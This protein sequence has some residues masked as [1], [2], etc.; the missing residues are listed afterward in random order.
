MTTA[1]PPEAPEDLYTCYLR[2]MED[3]GKSIEELLTDEKSRN[4]HRRTHKPMPRKEFERVV[5]KMELERRAEFE[6]MLRTPREQLRE[7]SME[8]AERALREYETDPEVRARVAKEAE[9][10]LAKALTPAKRK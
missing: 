10:S 3:S 6:K 4:F 9:E 5:K 8:E 7:E 2:L 1:T